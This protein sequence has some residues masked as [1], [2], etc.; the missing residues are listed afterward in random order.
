MLKIILSKL[1]L[2]NLP[3]SVITYHSDGGSR[4][5]LGL[6]T[7]LLCVAYHLT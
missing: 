5:A 7:H 3:E 4:L 1:K 2:I 6:E